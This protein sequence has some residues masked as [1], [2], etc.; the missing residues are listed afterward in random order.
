MTCVIS[1]KATTSKK[2]TG[3]VTIAWRGPC[4]SS[5]TGSRVTALS[6]ASCPTTS[7]SYKHN[8]IDTYYNYELQKLSLLRVGSGVEGSTT[9]PGWRSVIT[10]FHSDSKCVQANVSI[11]NDS[12]VSG[13]LWYVFG[14]A[15]YPILAGPDQ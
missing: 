15:W 11:G 3:K 1:I 9:V 8:L 12:S 13:W 10:L 2:N 7:R 6:V 14:G 4:W 5:D